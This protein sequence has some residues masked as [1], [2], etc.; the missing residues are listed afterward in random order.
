M[1]A[2]TTLLLLF[3]CLQDTVTLACQVNGK[4]RGTLEVARDV[5]QAG[6]VAAAL[7]NANV[8]KFAAEPG[9]SIKKVIFVPGKILNLI[10]G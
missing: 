5:D 8:A 1:L 9:K 6:A 2:C 10:V 3:A 7:A 4:V